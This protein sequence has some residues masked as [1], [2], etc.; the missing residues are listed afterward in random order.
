[1]HQVTAMTSHDL[2]PVNELEKDLSPHLLARCLL[3]STYVDMLSA[4]GWRVVRTT[5]GPRT[6]HEV[7]LANDS[8]WPSLL[9]T[10]EYG[11]QRRRAL[12]VSPCILEGR[13]SLVS[14]YA[15]E[16]GLR[17]GLVSRWRAGISPMDLAIEGDEIEK[18]ALVTRVHVRLLRSVTPD[19]E[20]RRRVA[21]SIAKEAYPDLLDNEQ[22]LVAAQLFDTL[23]WSW[24]R[25][26]AYSLLRNA[27]ASLLSGGLVRHASRRQPTRRVTDSP[28]CTQISRLCWR[29]F[30]IEFG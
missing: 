5:V 21:L 1:M 29:A 9:V 30:E 8:P 18:L 10:Q 16:I 20:R 23:D 6:Y 12:R 27:V 2:S 11:R 24:V 13:F 28:R 3:T 15:R 14:S 26:D 19:E 4:V 17:S 25:S 7:I 22:E